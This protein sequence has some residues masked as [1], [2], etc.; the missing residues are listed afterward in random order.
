MREKRGRR[1]V[2]KERGE[3]KRGL[4]SKGGRESREEREREK[5]SEKCFTRRYADSRLSL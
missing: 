4:E 5:V 1:K 2:E 3:R